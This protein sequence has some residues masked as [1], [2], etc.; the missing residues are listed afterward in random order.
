MPGSSQ[1]LGLQKL[2][3]SVYLWEPPSSNST[4]T[5]IHPSPCPPPKLVLLF[6][7][8][9]AQPVHIFKYIHNYQTHYPTSRILVI[10]SSPL[11]SLYHRTSTLRR[12]LTPAVHDL[13]ASLQPTTTSSSTNNNPELIIHIF[14]NGGS[15]Q[16]CNFISTYHTLTS[17]PFPTHIKILDSCPGRA[18]FRRTILALS[19]PLSSSPFIVR[20]PSLFLIYFLIGIYFITIRFRLFQD[21][22]LRV[23]ATLNDFSQGE[24]GRCYI[25]SKAD[26]MVGW[27]DVEAH[28]MEAMERGLRVKQE[29]YV[30]TGHCAHVREGGGV[31]YWEVVKGMWEDE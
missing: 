5:S 10:R 26:P 19:S 18:T 4:A 24:R 2:S 23:R 14:S 20:L 11:D 29:T 1:L 17:T 3:P 25:Y 9:S 28:A 16:F 7:W 12:C 8:M 15:H 31:R 22:I 27:W 13:L 30:G 6:T 21:P